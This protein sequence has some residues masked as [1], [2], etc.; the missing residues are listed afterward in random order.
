MSN[1]TRFQA[2]GYFGKRGW[3]AFC[4]NLMAERAWK[5]AKKRGGVKGLQRYGEDEERARISLSYK[6]NFSAGANAKSAWTMHQGD[7]QYFVTLPS[8]AFRQGHGSTGNVASALSFQNGALN[9]VSKFV[10]TT[11][12]IAENG[13]FT[14]RFQIPK[15]DSEQKGLYWRVS[16]G[17]WRFE[18]RDG[19]ASAYRV[20]DAWTD[21]QEATY[22]AHLAL[23][24]GGASSASQAAADEIAAVIYADGQSINTTR[25]EGWYDGAHEVSFLPDSRGVFSVVVEGEGAETAT[26]VEDTRITATRA[27]GVLWPATTL[28]IRS[29]GGAYAWQMGYPLFASTGT[30]SLGQFNALLGI[31]VGDIVVSLRGDANGGT[32]SGECVEINAAKWEIVITFVNAASNSP[33]LYAAQAFAQA[34]ERSGIDTVVFDTDDLAQNQ[35]LDVQPCWDDENKRTSV[36][37]IMRNVEGDLVGADGV[38]I[39][40]GSE[41]GSTHNFMHDRLAD[42]LVNG[43]TLLSRG[44]ITTSTPNNVKRATADLASGQWAKGDSK[45][46][47]FISDWWTLADEYLLTRQPVGDGQRMGAYIR[48]LLLMA[49]YKTTEI[50]GVSAAAGYILPTAIL[51][52][53]PCVQPALGTSLGDFL[54]G[55]LEK[56]AQ[57]W[58]LA[59]YTGAWV[60]AAKSVTVKAIFTKDA[61]W[62]QR[63]LPTPIYRIM[64]ELDLTRDFTETYNVFTVQGA[65]NEVGTPLTSTWK[66]EESFGYT[67]VEN[68]I[69][70]VKAYPTLVDEGLRTQS[71]VNYA[72][73]SLAYKYGKPGRFAEFTSWWVD[74]VHP[75]DRVTIDGL[76]FEVVRITSGSTAE[77]RMSF[78]CREVVGG[79]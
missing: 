37:V 67:L 5:A 52:E 51:G 21:A 9:A 32:I 17:V 73:R 78:A 56:Y 2:R 43:V 49:G 75:G 66:W 45:N 72:C 39:Y 12:L 1:T 74:N 53:A 22:N 28:G 11:S 48:Q 47:F 15:P 36:T 50:S 31:D 59:C 57:G 3:E 42:V 54:R 55:L 69:G 4:Q 46:T 24:S 65:K 44:I 35:I 8:R 77:D 14:I 19:N 64:T 16:W 58:T 20:T 6:T 38:T 41:N 34:G 40:P 18:I 13:P 25:A 79:F 61:T 76:T 62:A 10:S 71:A 27:S 7:S 26:D 23:L 30:L 70:R 63:S 60:F 68:F 29:S 33:V